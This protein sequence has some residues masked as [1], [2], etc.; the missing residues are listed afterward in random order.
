M[1]HFEEIGHKYT[2]FTDPNKK[3]TSLT[4]VLE[5]YHEHF[6]DTAEFW[7][8]YKVIQYLTKDL[9]KKIN[10][11]DAKLNDLIKAECF[12]WSDDVYLYDL[13]EGK[14][15]LAYGFKYKHFDGI[16][17]F[18]LAERVIEKCI[19][20]I[21]DFWNKGT[22][23]ACEEGT[24]LHWEKEQIQK[25]IYDGKEY[26]LEQWIW[27]EDKKMFNFKPGFMYNEVRLCSHEH[28][29]SGSCDK[30]MIPRD[31]TLIIRDYKSN[32]EIKTKAY[33]NKTMFYPV[34]NY[35]DTEYGKYSL[36][37]NGYAFMLS[38]LG[39]R[40]DHLQFEHFKRK[41]GGGF[42]DDAIIYPVKLD[43]EAAERL[44][45]HFALNQSLL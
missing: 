27:S 4:T 17:F 24:G 7:K 26:H 43:L 34:S 41:P 25:E 30:L 23:V 1:L 10:K 21:G 31:N 40:L 15:I 38:K 20:V 9:E 6:E 22:A 29:I 3:F 19:K 45:D 42:V 2:S 35:S 5:M 28:S 44:F 8:Q 37:L 14:D 16:E 12:K 36:Q 32:K 39:Y 11:F 13:K 33:M 18:P